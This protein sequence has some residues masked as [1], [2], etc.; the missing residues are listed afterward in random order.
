MDGFQD[1][2][3]VSLQVSSIATLLA[4]VPGIWIGLFLGLT[5]F[6]GRDFIVT[7]LYTAL[8]FPTV[9]VGLMIY[10]FLSR[11]GPLG[12]WNLLYTRS[13]IV[14]GQMFLILP[15]ISTFTLSAIRRLDPGMVMTAR[16]LG[17]SPMKIYFTV[18]REALFG[19]IAAII[20]AFGRAISEVGVSMILGGNILGYTR[21][22]TT[23]IALEH[24]KGQFRQAIILGA[25]L[26][27]ISLS[28][29]V[30]FHLLQSRTGASDD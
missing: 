23:A 11:S 10:M 14:I 24:D 25:I 18:S 17:A 15:I 22:M 30:M 2:I 9:V 29:N 12:N 1:A 28:I 6:R 21:T 3:I 19:I 7:L 26:L 27:A 4:T 5:K 20:A 8:A 13:A 16:S